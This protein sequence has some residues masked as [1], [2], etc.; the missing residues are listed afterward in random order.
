M[1]VVVVEATVASNILE[2]DSERVDLVDVFVSSLSPE[3]LG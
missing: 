1:V 3:D 2:S